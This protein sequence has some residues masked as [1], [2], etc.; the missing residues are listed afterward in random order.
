L[1]STTLSQ[2]KTLSNNIKV[3][4]K[5]EDINE[6][7]KSFNEF[8]FRK[9]M[10]FEIE[11]DKIILKVEEMLL[12]FAPMFKEKYKEVLPGAVSRVFENNGHFSQAEF[13]ELIRDI[14]RLWTKK[15]EK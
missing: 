3:L 12:Q 4:R 13:P 14:R 10:N 11:N 15:Y 8:L 7:I 2:E 5:I 1:T 9:K 6:K